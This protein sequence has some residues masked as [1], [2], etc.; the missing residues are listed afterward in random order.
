LPNRAKVFAAGAFTLAEKVWI[1]GV[2]EVLENLWNRLA[3]EKP[4]WEPIENVA[5]PG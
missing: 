3:D 2:E 1:A 4:T 5:S